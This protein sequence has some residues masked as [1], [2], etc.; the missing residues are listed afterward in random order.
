MLAVPRN[1]SLWVGSNRVEC[2][3]WHRLSA[4]AGSKGERGYDWQCRVL[5][6]PEDAAWGRYLLF[7]RF[8]ADPDGWL[9]YV[10]FA[11]QSCG[12]EMLM[13]VAGSHWHIEH[14]FKA[15]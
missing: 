12:L 6:E 9:A 2:Q 4:G 10:A 15:A 13:A 5:A 14:A 8:L 1:E 3:E 11:P 7:H